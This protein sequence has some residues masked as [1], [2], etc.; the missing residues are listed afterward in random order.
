MGTPACLQRVRP[1][2]SDTAEEKF[3]LAVDHV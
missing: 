2:V 1:I 3:I